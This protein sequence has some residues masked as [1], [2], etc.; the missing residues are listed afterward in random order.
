M[1][2]W[3]SASGKAWTWAFTAYPGVWALVALLAFTYARLVRHDAP[4]A[5]HRATGWIG[6]LTIW[7]ALDWPLGPL[8]AGYLASAHALQFLLVALI[9]PPLLLLGARAGLVTWWTTGG[10]RTTLGRVVGTLGKPLVAAILFNFVT[11]A[12]HVPAVVDGWMTSQLGA[13]AIDACWLAGG[14]LFWWPIVVPAPERPW[15]GGG[16]K[17]LYLFLGTVFHTGIA[18]AMLMRDYPMY[19]IYELAPP[20]SGM[21]AMDDI[22]IAGGIMELAGSAIVFGVMTVMFFRWS[23]EAGNP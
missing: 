1:Q 10:E 17:L 8:A 14:L 5:R 3:C 7:L 19:A 6:V 2:F 18:I 13:F 23:R 21:S 4:D 16:A 11:I 15:F 20:M 9:A 22:K 12:T